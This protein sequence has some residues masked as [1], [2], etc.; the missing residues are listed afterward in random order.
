MVQLLFIRIRLG[1]G[2][3]DALCDNF[4]IALLVTGVFAVLALHPRRVL[5]ELSTQS[6]SHNVVEL[7]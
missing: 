5:E 1:I 4:R 7:L 2:L 6:T 3:A